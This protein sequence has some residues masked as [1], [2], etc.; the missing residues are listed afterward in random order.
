MAGSGEPFDD[1]TFWSDGTGWIDE[2]AFDD[3]FGLAFLL[4]QP[5]DDGFGQGFGTVSGFSPAFS[6]ESFREDAGIG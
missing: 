2:N 4:D 5:V 1:G 6:Q 3:G